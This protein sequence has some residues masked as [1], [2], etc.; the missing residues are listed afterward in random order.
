MVAKVTSKYEA[1]GG[2]IHGI[3][4]EPDRLAAAGAPP[5]GG[6]TSNIKVKISKGNK[7]FGI[8]PRGVRLARLVGTAPDTFRKYSFLPVLTATAF[9]GTGFALGSTVTIST[10]DWEVVAKISEDY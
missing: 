5:T 3:I 6:V 7:E 10:V 4:L 1:D 9:N 2:A 8:R